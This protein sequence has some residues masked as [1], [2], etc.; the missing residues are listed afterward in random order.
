VGDPEAHIARQIAYY[1]ARA[2][3][4]DEDMR[5]AVRSTE[6]GHVL[7]AQLRAFAPRGRVL[8]VACGTGALTA[9]LVAFADEIT[10]VDGSKEMIGVARRRVT[11]PKV[12]FVQADVFSWGPDGRYDAVV[13]GFWL[14]HIP[15]THFEGFWDLVARCLEPGGRVFFMDEGR[16]EQWEE[17][18][19]DE[20]AGVVR[21]HL[22]DGSEHRAI[23]VLWDPM[24][25]RARLSELGWAVE[26]GTIGPF[27]WGHGTRRD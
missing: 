3:E 27:Y 21:R 26:V 14:S 23:K 13:F 5:R 25:L 4:Y 16:Q 12:R 6:H 17:D 8:E 1:D 10:A 19:I 11:S 22:R 18:W 2:G 9:D 15:P 20:A 7:D 24:E